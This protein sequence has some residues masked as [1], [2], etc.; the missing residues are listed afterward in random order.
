MNSYY[1][2]SAS[3]KGNRLVFS[4]PHPYLAFFVLLFFCFWG[5]PTSLLAQTTCCDSNRVLQCNK[6]D[7]CDL[8]DNDPL[9]W[10]LD[11]W[12]D[13]T[14]SSHDLAEMSIDLSL[15]VPDVCSD[16][17]VKIRYL[18]FLDLDGN[19][20]Q[21]TVVN[22]EQLPGTNQV[23]YGNAMTAN[24]AGGVP[25]AFDHRSVLNPLQDWYGFATELKRDSSKLTVSVRFH[26][27]RNPDTYVL[28]QLPH[29]KH[30]IRWVVED[31]CGNEA[32]CEYAFEV[33]DCKKPTVVC[34]PLSVNIMQT[35][36]V[37]LWA[38][39]FLEYAFDNCTPTDQLKIAVSKGEPAPATFPRDPIT[40]LPLTQLNFFCADLGPNVIQLWMEDARGNAE[41]CQ[42][43]LLVQDNVGNCAPSSNIGGHITTYDGKGIEETYINI[44]GTHP[45]FPPTIVSIVTGFNGQYT[46]SSGIP[47]AGNYSICPVKDDNPLNGVTTLDLALI[48]KHVIGLAVLDNPYKYIAADANKS[49]TITTFDVVELR[50]L[51]L[52][53]YSELPNNTSWRFIAKPHQFANPLNPFQSSF[54]ECL[55]IASLGGGP[56]D[57]IGVK[58][59]DVN[60]TA[61]SNNLINEAEG[62]ATPSLALQMANRK[63]LPGDVFEV[64]VQAA[65]T[66]LAQ[67]FTLHFPHLELLEILPATEGMD[68]G[69]FAHFHSQHLLTHAWNSEGASGDTPRFTLRFR[70]LAAGRLSELLALTENPT[71]TL[72]YTTNGNRLK[73]NLHFY[74]T[75]AKVA[76]EKLVLLQNQPNPFSHTTT[77]RFYLPQDDQVRLTV[78]DEAGKILLQRDIAGTKGFNQTSIGLES[79]LP[80]GIFYYKMATSTGEA[81][82]KMMRQ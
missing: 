41:Y 3:A 27:A 25:R 42:V 9:F 61:V 1:P 72:A 40:G 64:E 11:Y 82:K 51:I 49:G 54:P 13:A 26:T 45:A 58:I 74:E 48:S 66:L 20:T 21:E 33:R 19:N 59:G 8:S 57:F 55:T 52:G 32:V 81:T 53:I 39:D 65:Q 69:H 43:V 75:P 7:T 23:F 14:H 28:P 15:T 18:L 70:A 60:N 5:A 30:K 10:N 68:E 80:R 36:M 50:K 76:M 77:I 35:K 79:Q 47:L 16:S 22:S 71:P 46:I 56:A 29:G 37:T 62:R 12:W 63:V 4:T 73:P 38:Y 6:P 17:A 34:K 31:S 2:S 44:Q 24:Y 78:F 67:Q